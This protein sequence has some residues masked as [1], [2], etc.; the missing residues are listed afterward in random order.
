M[1]SNPDFLSKEKKNVRHRIPKTN[2][3]NKNKNNLIH[4]LKQLINIHGLLSLFTGFCFLSR[5]GQARKQK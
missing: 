3:K 1:R 2:N 5:D 4:N